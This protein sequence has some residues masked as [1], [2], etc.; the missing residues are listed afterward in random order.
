[1]KL[2]G[3]TEFAPGVSFS[4]GYTHGCSV[5][6]VHA[7]P[8][9]APDEKPHCHSQDSEYFH[10]LKGELRIEVDGRK[11]VIHPDQCLET[12]PGEKHKILSFKPGTEYIV[13]RTNRLPGEKAY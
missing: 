13:V 6:I 2:I 7:K 11:V 9:K 8:N 5:M 3:S 4:A 10:I 1:M 12:E